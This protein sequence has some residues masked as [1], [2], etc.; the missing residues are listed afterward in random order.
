VAFSIDSLNDEGGTENQLIALIRGMDLQRFE[1][2][3]VCI[4]DGERLQQL[5]PHATPLIFPMTSIFSLNGLRGILRLR[6]E[7]KRQHI[8]IVH[9]FMVRGTLLGVLAASGS[10]CNVVLTSRRNMG[11]WYTHFYRCVFRVLN[12]M[13]SR[14]VANSEAAKRAAI[15]IEGLP[16]SRVDV[17]YNGV[18]LDL[19]SGIGDRSL[20]DQLGVPRESR[21]IGIVANYR[22]VKNLSMFLR[23]ASL[24]AARHA[25][26]IFLL[27]GRGPLRRSLGELAE[28]LGI[29]RKV[30][31]TDG[32][33][34]VSGYVPLMDVGCISSLNEGFS[35]A[36]LEYMA[37]G[38]AVVAT[39]VGGN[40]E[41]V[42]D[43][44]TGFLTPAGDETTFARRVIT[45]LEDEALR[46]TMG[47]GGRAR[48]TERFEM[49]ATIR[50]YEHYYQSL[51][52]GS[53]K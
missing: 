26:T 37:R 3:A 25:D 53:A 33:G 27:V 15:K 7:I 51:L 6:G 32:A 1:L 17:L 19:F 48:C 42:V 52:K 16:A 30:F 41:A 14:V 31:F 4:D 44:V 24:I 34:A 38:L 10:A 18:D 46:K 9:A 47:A 50:R 49:K 40:R 22:S 2:F 39:D 11:D 28:T 35:N 23:A 5:A 12:R 36:I 45:L 20:L 43:G 21:I 29:A 8:D 13:T